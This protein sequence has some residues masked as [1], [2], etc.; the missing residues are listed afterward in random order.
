MYLERP[1]VRFDGVYVSR[2]TYFRLGAVTMEVKNP[3]HLCVY[4]R[5]YRFFPVRRPRRPCNAGQRI[6]TPAVASRGLLPRVPCL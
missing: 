6:E 5:Y 3:V 4:Y 1:H 2:N